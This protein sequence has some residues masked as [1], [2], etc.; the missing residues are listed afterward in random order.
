M[1]R[2]IALLFATLIAFIVTASNYGTNYPEGTHVNNEKRKLNSVTF[3]VEGYP[4]QTLEINQGFNGL[5]YF[6]KE[7]YCFVAEAGSNVDL[8][9]DWDG[10]WMNS[11]VYIDLNQDN[12]F[13]AETELIAY[14][15]LGGKNSAGASTGD[16]NVLLPPTFQI[17]DWL[18]GA[19][20]MRIKIDW[21]SN[22][23]GGSMAQGND[24]IK[25]GGAIV[26][27]KLF[28][29]EKASLSVTSEN[30]TVTLLDGTLA[31]GAIVP[32]TG[33]LDLIVTPNDGYD[34]DCLT[35]SSGFANAGNWTFVNEDFAGISTSYTAPAMINGVIS[36][37]VEKLL[38][39]PEITV[40]FI[41]LQ[42][43]QGSRYEGFYSGAKS[44]TEGYTAVAINGSAVSF[45]STALH[46]PA[47]AANMVN[48]LKGEAISVNTTYS[49]T[50]AQHQLLVDLNQ[51][52]RFNTNVQSMSCE[53]VAS[54]DDP[55]NL[56]GTLPDFIKNGVYR[57][58]MHAEGHSSVDFFINLHN[59]TAS[60]R[61]QS[62]NA[63][64]LTYEGGAFPNEAP[65]F[66][67]LR[68]KSSAAVPGFSAEKAVIRHGQNLSGPQFI[69]GNPQWVDTEVNI[70]T[71]GAISISKS[72]MNGDAEIYVLYS[73]DEDSEWVK[74]WG[75]EFNE[76]KLDSKRWI[77]QE[78]QG[79]TWNR[80]IAQ[81]ITQRRLVNT[82]ENGVYNSHCIPTPESYTTETQP[83]ISGAI[84]SSGKFAVRYGRIEARLKT[85]PHTGNFPAFWMMPAYTEL[86]E[87]GLSGW[88]MDGEIDIWEQIDTQN[89]SH[90]TVHSGWTGWN[91]YCGWEA[92]K[93]NSP[94]SSGSVGCDMNLWHVYALEW[95]A[96]ELRWFVDGKQVFSYRNQH[97]VEEGSDK[98]I[99]K[100]TWPFDKHFY[101]I[102]N[103]S[104]G[105]GSWAANADVNFHYLTMFDYVRV[106]QKKDEVDCQTSFK[107]NGDD[108]NFYVP[109]KDADE[110]TSIVDIYESFSGEDTYYDLH[111]RRI[112]NPYSAPGI[113][114]KK[115]GSE[116]SKIL[117]Q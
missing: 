30:G 6:D 57:A 82:F 116:A 74:V 59:A 61:L 39:N 108:P 52:G 58:R 105:N 54:G 98:Y 19:Q 14:S 18:E 95:D 28:I 84:N 31:N 43:E 51:D 9:L 49:G 8:R 53:I 50:A 112:A 66:T 104:V 109:A 26:D 2:Q 76:G 41:E 69:C 42:G 68:L 80:L 93:V 99:E 88:P 70:L 65:L 24:I 100:I 107:G 73:Q 117:I 62:L 27:V 38:G 63:L 21:D 103:Q 75:D 34:F 13:D 91:A 17:P 67:V 86:S 46:E 16:G 15:N 33:T 94:Q 89:R 114:I 29:A 56:N 40:Q 10:V 97:Y 3:D 12:V 78:R 47:K 48:L 106:Y 32:E 35:V 55:T 101:I 90:H 64:V 71:S 83:M 44:A 5:L 36:V 87:L 23:P 37:P 110:E 81:T 7:S 45:A 111:G 102:L 1:N 22:D 96:E 113:Y 60:L 79:A 25:N 77:Y 115:S 11:Y 4:A 20:N 72:L 92:P 85:T